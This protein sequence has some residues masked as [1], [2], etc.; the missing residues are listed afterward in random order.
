[1]NA[2]ADQLTGDSALLLYFSKSRTR[3]RNSSLRSTHFPEFVVIYV[4]VLLCKSKV[5]LSVVAMIVRIKQD[6]NSF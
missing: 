2:L 6:D 4:A 5:F 3:S 1:M